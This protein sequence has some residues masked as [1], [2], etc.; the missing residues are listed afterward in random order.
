[1]IRHSW[2]C[3]LSPYARWNF[4]S[5]EKMSDL[6]GLGRYIHYLG[7]SREKLAWVWSRNP[8]LHHPP[9]LR[10]ATAGVAKMQEYTEDLNYF[11]QVTP[12]SFKR[13][14]SMAFW[15]SMSTLFR[16]E[17]ALRQRWETIDLLRVSLQ[18]VT[19]G[20]Q[21]CNFLVWEM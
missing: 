19:L 4:P 8:S 9:H 1:M 11:L 14:G 17:E 15:D 16:W 21:F 3:I 7:K 18:G 2:I 6:Q 12:I 5:L 13:E 20:D 10:R